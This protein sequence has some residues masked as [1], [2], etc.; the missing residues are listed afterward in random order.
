MQKLLFSYAD[1]EQCI[2]GLPPHY[3]ACTD[4]DYSPSHSIGCPTAYWKI[5]ERIWQI[6]LC[7][8]RKSRKYFCDII[9]SLTWFTV[10]LKLHAAVI[11]VFVLYNIIMSPAL[12]YKTYDPVCH[13]VT[14]QDT[15]PECSC[16]VEPY[17][18]FLIC[19]PPGCKVRN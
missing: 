2:G 11:I 3:K 14:T 4:D 13:A 12:C 7:T 17:D 6:K 9:P 15:E 10:A 8:G 16:E 5:G 1:G 19:D 18:G